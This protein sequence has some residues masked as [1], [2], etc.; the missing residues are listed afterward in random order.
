VRLCLTAPIQSARAFAN[1]HADLTGTADSR[2]CSRKTIDSI[3]CAFVQVCVKG[4]KAEIQ[5]LVER[6]YHEGVDSPGRPAV[7]S[8]ASLAPGQICGSGS[9]QVHGSETRQSN[10]TGVRFV[11]LLHVQDEAKLRLRDKEGDTV[12]RSRHS[13]VQVHVCSLWSS[14]IPSLDVLTELDPLADKRGETVATSFDRVLR[15]VAG[16]VAAG[17]P[18]ESKEF[19]F[20]VHVLIGDGIATNRKAARILWALVQREPLPGNF[21][22]LL[23]VVVCASHQSNLTVGSF[24]DGKISTTAA[25]TAAAVGA[26]GGGRSDE[27]ARGCR[28][29][30][31]SS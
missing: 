30:Q 29:R 3:R 31:C 24:C 2:G 4:G 13:K 20:L 15:D 23:W 26:A 18:Q 14:L 7:A 12:M 10:A 28:G 19:C 27:V 1:V 25:M 11:V 8:S 22:Y 9:R 21:T 16:H 6:I 5:D 17:I